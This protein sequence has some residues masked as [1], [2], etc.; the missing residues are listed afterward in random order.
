MKIGINGFE[1]VVPRF[2]YDDKGLP[3]RVGSSEFCFQLL[4][5]L[6]VLDKK[7]EYVVYLPQEPTADMPKE[8]SNWKY[9]VIP[10]KKLWTIFGL[11]KNLIK[12]KNLD[13]F[14]SPTHY[15][16]LFSS[17]PQIISI[18]DVSYKRF[19]EMFPKKD[20]LKLALWGKLSIRRAKKIITISNSSKNDI[21]NEYRVLAN[22]VEVI[23]L[24]IKDVNASDMNKSEFIEK[25]NLKNPYVLFVGTLQPRKNIA[26]LVEAFAKLESRIKNQESRTKGLDLVIVGRKGWDYEKILSAPDKFGISERVKFLENV[27]NEDLPLFYKNAEVFVLPSLYE[28]F[29]LPILEAMQNECPVVTSNVSS[30]PEAGGDA[31]LYFDPNDTD[32]IAEK[33]EKVISDPKLREEMV[34]KGKEQIK[35]FSWEKSAKE[36]IRVFET[37]KG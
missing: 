13:L 15:A 3:R 7:N 28:G 2:G 36:V 24:G 16:P 8:S 27:T 19:P 33:I 9:K 4:K 17:C 31:A 30:L 37:L 22:K 25:Y 14:F 21:I 34:R 18:L 5:N 11:S 29:G 35:K 1:A 26:K 12:E 23:P 10:N 20:L 32:D 6:S